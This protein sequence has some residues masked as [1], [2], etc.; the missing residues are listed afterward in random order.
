MMINKAEVRKRLVEMAVD[1]SYHWREA[2][3]RDRIRVRQSTFEEAN[4]ALDNWCRAKI[5]RMANKGMTI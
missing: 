5:T 3:G 2:I 4:A 1:N